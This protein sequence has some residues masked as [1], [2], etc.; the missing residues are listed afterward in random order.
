MFSECSLLE[1]LQHPNIV[2]MSQWFETEKHVYIVMELAKNGT[3]DFSI[4][5]FILSSAESTQ[6]TYSTLSTSVNSLSQKMY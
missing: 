3:F 4:G 1:K 2:E 6:A 5:S